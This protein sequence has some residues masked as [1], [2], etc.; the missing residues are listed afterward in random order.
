M[1]PCG[2]QAKEDSSGTPQDLQVYIPHITY[3]DMTPGSRF[4]R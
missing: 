1:Q 2:Q 3:S 4:V